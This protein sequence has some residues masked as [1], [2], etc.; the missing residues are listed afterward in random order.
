MSATEAME[1]LRPLLAQRRAVESLVQIFEAAVQA[2]ALVAAQTQ[3]QALAA[4]QAAPIHADARRMNGATIH[5][6][7]A[8][9]DLWRGTP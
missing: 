9:D 4:A 3:R 2:E 1:T 5:G 8:P 7:G 6:T